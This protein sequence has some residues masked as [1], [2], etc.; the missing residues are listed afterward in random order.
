M[1]TNNHFLTEKNNSPNRFHETMNA[2][3]WR[4]QCIGGDTLKSPVWDRGSTQL[5]QDIKVLEKE[6]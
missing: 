4:R 2:R 6:S 3:V 1:L 5:A